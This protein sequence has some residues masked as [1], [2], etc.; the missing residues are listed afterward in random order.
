MQLTIFPHTWTKF[1]PGRV[2]P[3]TNLDVIVAFLHP[4]T[5]NA[6]FVSRIGF[7]VQQL[8]Q[9]LSLDQFTSSQ[10]GAI[11]R[12]NA[13]VLG[14]E[15]TAVDGNP[16]HSAVFTLGN[17]TRVMQMWTLKGNKAYIM[18]YQASPNEYPTNLPTFQSIL[19]SLTIKQQ[20]GQTQL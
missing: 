3:Q 14:S 2:S 5:Q 9:N 12:A 8:A 7:G 1:Q 16:G 15:D 19:D 6:S 13:T 4:E 11:N 17:T 18:S 10:T 20:Y